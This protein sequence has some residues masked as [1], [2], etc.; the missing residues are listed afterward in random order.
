MVYDNFNDVSRSIILYEKL[1]RDE[2]EGRRISLDSWK[3]FVCNSLATTTRWKGI[4]SPRVYRFI[5]GRK[6]ENP[7]RRLAD[8]LALRTP[9]LYAPPPVIELAFERKLQANERLF[10]NTIPKVVSAR[11]KAW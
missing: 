7:P 8:P 10:H 3:S 6:F 5:L 4:A 9:F 2:M 1:A 11:R